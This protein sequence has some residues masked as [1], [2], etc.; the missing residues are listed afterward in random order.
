MDLMID[1]D[2]LVEKPDTEMYAYSSQLLGSAAD[3]NDDEDE[4]PPQ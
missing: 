4:E 2:I 1:S 3:V